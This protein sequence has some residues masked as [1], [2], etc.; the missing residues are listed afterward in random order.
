MSSN[1]SFK[2]SLE[3][4]TCASGSPLIARPDAVVGNSTQ[5]SIGHSPK[6]LLRQFASTFER[7]QNCAETIP[8]PWGAQYTAL[9]TPYCVRKAAAFHPTPVLCLV[10]RRTFNIF[11]PFNHDLQSKFPPFS[12]S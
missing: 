8:A 7:Y 11:E 12:T 9:F 10:Y 4:F 6:L 3:L 5:T 1:R 2:S